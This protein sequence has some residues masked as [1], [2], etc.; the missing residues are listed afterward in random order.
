MQRNTHTLDASGKIAGRFASS[1]AVLLQGKHK[2]SYQAHTDCG[3]LVEVSNVGKMAFSGRKLTRKFYH[4][5]T[6]YPGGIRSVRLDELFQKKPDLL[7]KKMV[8]NMLPKNKLR[9][10]MLKRLRFVQDKK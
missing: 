10:K 4:R 6:G 1:I 9:A 2:P 7:L 3:D 5:F 8:F